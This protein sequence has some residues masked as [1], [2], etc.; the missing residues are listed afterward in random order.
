[1]S[2]PETCIAEIPWVNPIEVTIDFKRKYLISPERAWVDCGVNE[3]GR[4]YKAPIGVV[5]YQQR[6][7]AAKGALSTWTV[8]PET[9]IEARKSVVSKIINLL[10][11][12]YSS[13][14]V[15]TKHTVVEKLRAVF[16]WIDKEYLKNGGPDIDFE[17]IDSLKS[18]YRAYTSHLK[19]LV[20]LGQTGKT[21]VSTKKLPISS[22]RQLQFS[23]RV[24]IRACVGVDDDAI[25]SWTEV[26]TQK[27]N[28]HTSS[29]KP[30]D[31]AIHRF[32]SHLIEV[33]EVFY[34]VY[35][36]GNQDILNLEKWR[37]MQEPRNLSKKEGHLK[38]FTLVGFYFMVLATGQNESV[39]LGLKASE[40]KLNRLN[41]TTYRVGKK[42]RAKGKEIVIEMGSEHKSIFDKYLA[43]RNATALPNNTFLFPSYEAELDRAVYPNKFLSPTWIKVL[44]G[45]IFKARSLREF[46]AR[47]IGKVAQSMGSQ[48]GDINGIIARMLQNKPLTACQ[49]SAE[50]L[51]QAAEPLSK[52]FGEL[53]DACIEKSRTHPKI[54]VHLIEH[55]ETD[56]KTPA[57]TCQSADKPTPMLAQGFTDQ[58]TQPACGK[59]ETC[60]FCENYGVH[61]DE[62]DLKKLLSL[63]AV[64]EV[65]HQG[66]DEGEYAKRFAAL[67]AR[68]QEVMDAMLAKNTSLEDKLQG[69]QEACQTGDLDDFWASYMR[70]LKL[71]GFQPGGML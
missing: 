24:L 49:Y 59:W 68:I 15:R 57:G 51:E 3:L 70:T 61:A 14:S 35:V 69:L 63:K 4:R 58:A 38:V 10:C 37:W 45:T 21:S 31:E 52:F 30:S 46:Y 40:V 42:G 56:R 50:S 9:L 32:H 44:G 41:K 7:V 55:Q 11:E 60:L 6:R 12:N 43:V 71:N 67:I 16:D 36:L 28:P 66:M 13:A 64:I 1:M 29:Q 47:R 5:C 26:L 2:I 39:L 18:M 53:H 22:A 17:S 8:R 25:K 48:S 54:K 65:L 34:G 33:I 20:L 19:H 27:K 23:A 62:I